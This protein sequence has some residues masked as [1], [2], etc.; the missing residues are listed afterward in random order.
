MLVSKSGFVLNTTVMPDVTGT[1]F[2]VF[3]IDDGYLKPQTK[4][5]PAFRCH[6]RVEYATS[7]SDPVPKDQIADSKK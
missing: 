2:P 4:Y 5:F 1:R 6:P 7:A 3:K